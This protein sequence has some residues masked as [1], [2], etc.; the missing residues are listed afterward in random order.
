M[1]GWQFLSVLLVSREL[2]KIDLGDLGL[3]LAQNIINDTQKL[4][5]L[6]ALKLV[7]VNIDINRRVSVSW[8]ESED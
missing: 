6:L 2:F 7:L 1:N 5:L 4:L 8:G 3:W